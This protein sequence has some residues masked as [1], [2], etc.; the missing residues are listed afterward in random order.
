[1]W[2]FL[3]YLELSPFA[4]NRIHP[5]NEGNGEEDVSTNG[6][7]DDLCL[8]SHKLLGKMITTLK[9][10]TYMYMYVHLTYN[11]M[12][13]VQCTCTFKLQLVYIL[14]CMYMYVHLHLH[15]ITFNTYIYC[16]CTV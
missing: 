9:G 4:N 13:N 2:W 12:Y 3:Y 15:L 7:E 10:L 14:Q 11:Y 5:L 8:L 6:D 1:M 16:I